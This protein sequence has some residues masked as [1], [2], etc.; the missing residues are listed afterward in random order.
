MNITEA[1]QAASLKGLGIARSSWIED[2]DFY[3]LPTNTQECMLV[4]REGKDH[5]PRWNP[6]M[7]DL[8]ATDWIVTG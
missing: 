1:I 2:N 3:I 8:L 7:E 4:I 6:N 5:Y